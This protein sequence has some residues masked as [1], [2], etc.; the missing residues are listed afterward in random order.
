MS[1]P[2]ESA[3]PTTSS[4]FMALLWLRRHCTTKSVDTC[5]SN[6]NA[7]ASCYILDRLVLCRASESGSS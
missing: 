2:A 6:S 5:G 7:S 3:A 1:T 4:L